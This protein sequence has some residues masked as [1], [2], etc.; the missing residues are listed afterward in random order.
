M[1]KRDEVGQVGV[2]EGD[3]PLGQTTFDGLATLEQ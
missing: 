1:G 2:G 3:E